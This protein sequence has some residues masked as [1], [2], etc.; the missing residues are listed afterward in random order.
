[1]PSPY[2]IY[3]S[4]GN[5]N[6]MQNL[7]PVS[8]TAN[9]FYLVPIA[10]DFFIV[11]KEAILTLDS[12]YIKAFGK[13]MLSKR[14]GTMAFHGS[15]VAFVF[16]LNAILCTFSMPSLN[17]FLNSSSCLANF[18]QLSLSSVANSSLSSSMLSYPIMNI[19]NSSN[20]YNSDFHH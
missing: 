6:R 8:K 18:R 5:F 17:Y 10:S 3:H 20:S 4:P 9:L 15:L 13:L 12:K 19:N 14:I 11:S 16:I 2:E 1:M 7:H